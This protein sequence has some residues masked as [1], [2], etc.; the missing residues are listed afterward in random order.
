MPVVWEEGAGGGLGV[1]R[2]AESWGV[3]LGCT[4]RPQ[5]DFDQGVTCLDLL[6]SGP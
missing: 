2:G 3:V 4:H 5:Q 6:K 1:S